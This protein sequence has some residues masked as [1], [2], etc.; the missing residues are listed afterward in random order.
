MGSMKWAKPAHDSNEGKS[1]NDNC[2]ASLE[3][4]QPRLKQEEGG[5]GTKT[6]E[7]KMEFM[8]LSIWKILLEFWTESWSTCRG[9][10]SQ[11]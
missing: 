1:Q 10:G 5:S 2:I 11:L 8:H 9:G 4:S 7:K 3:I 6:L